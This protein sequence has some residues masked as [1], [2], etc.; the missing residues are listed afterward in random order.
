MIPSLNLK[1]MR[2]ATLGM[3]VLIKVSQVLVSDLE[4]LACHRS[5][6]SG[7]RS[8]VASC[9]TRLLNGY[10]LTVTSIGIADSHNQNRGIEKY[11][12]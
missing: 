9:R 5:L 7:A 8:L 3:V 11:T 4:N 2:E 1:R 6:H 12:N 10:G